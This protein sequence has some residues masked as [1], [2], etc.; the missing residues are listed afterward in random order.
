MTAQIGA[1][2]LD[3]IGEPRPELLVE[4][5]RVEPQRGG[6]WVDLG[7]LGFSSTKKLQLSDQAGDIVVATWPAELAPQARYLYGS[8]LGSPLVAAAIER[9]WTVE[10][11]PHL[12]FRNAAPS[13]RLYMSPSVAPLDYAARWEDEDALVRIGNH[14]R[15]GVE[16]ELWPWLKDQGYADDGDDAELQR[17]LDDFLLGWPALMRPGPR[18]RRVWTS[19]DATDLGSALAEEIRNE[20]DA[21]FAVADEPGLS[22]D[23][24]PSA[25]VETTYDRATE[26]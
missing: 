16:D 24:P 8:R 7:P 4:V 18:F 10:P 6:E 9:G 20:F 25:E 11:S 1:E 21:L 23:R 22:S 26:E 12:A 14:T 17:F 5:A 3:L 13:R 15:E 2:G 19:D